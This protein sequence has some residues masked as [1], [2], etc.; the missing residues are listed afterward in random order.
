MKKETVK[1][2]FEF[3]E[4]KEEKE[5]LIPTLVLDP[6]SLES[7]ETEEHLDLSF[8]PIKELPKTVKIGGD[9]IL[10]YSTI[11]KLPE[12]LEV[13]GTLDLT[14]TYIQDLPDGLQVG[15]AIG[16]DLRLTGTYVEYL[17]YYLK[18]RGDLYIGNTP[19]LVDRRTGVYL[20]QK[21]IRQILLD[22]SGE[23]WGGIYGE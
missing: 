22:K 9:L 7:F 6:H 12:N 1:K 17:P 4:K 21:D 10:R 11:E 5:T 19:L 13:G 15:F 14:Q 20:T 23:V 8:L 2:F 16:G 3:L 18:V